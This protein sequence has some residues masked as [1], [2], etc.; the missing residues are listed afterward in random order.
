MSSLKYGCLHPAPVTKEYPVASGVFFYHNGV[1]AV[2]LDGNGRLALAVTATATLLGIAVVPTGMGAGSV[3]TYWKSAGAGVDK[4]PVILV[5]SNYDFLLPSDGTP[6]I[7]NIGDACDLI[8][9][10]DGT[11]TTV[12]IGTSSTDVFIIQDLG[13]NV[14]AYAVATDVIVKLNPAKRQA[15]T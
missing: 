9:V 1:N 2:Y 11:A 14:H 4:I 13:V 5:D 15:D 6:A 10:D 8:A 12:D 3:A 7:T